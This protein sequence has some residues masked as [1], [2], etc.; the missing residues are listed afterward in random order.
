M[1]EEGG[2]QQVWAWLGCGRRE[3]VALERGRVHHGEGSVVR[4]FSKTL[5]LRLVKGGNYGKFLRKFC[6]EMSK[7]G[8]SVGVAP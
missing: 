2:R 1:E 5:H 6:A 4:R 3:G 7:L 8:L